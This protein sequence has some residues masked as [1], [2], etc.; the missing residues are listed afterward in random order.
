MRLTADFFVA[1]LMREVR[2]RGGFAY[3]VRRGAHEAGALFILHHCRDGRH[4]LYGPAPQ[5]LY[6]GDEAADERLFTLLLASVSQEETLA[7]LEKELRFDPDI[8][9]IEIENLDAL[10]DVLKL[11]SI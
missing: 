7:Y 4:A 9:L 1:A 2:G 3:L 8:W 11:V 5:S 6:G 10:D